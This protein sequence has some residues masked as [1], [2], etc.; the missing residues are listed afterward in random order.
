MHANTNWMSKCL[1]KLAMPSDYVNAQANGAYQMKLET[2]DEMPRADARCPTKKEVFSKRQKFPRWKRNSL[3]AHHVKEVPEAR[4][5]PGT[6]APE[7]LRERHFQLW[8]LEKGSFGAATVKQMLQE[9]KLAS[10]RPSNVADEKDKLRKEMELAESHHDF[11]EV[12]RIKNRLMELEVLSLQS[13]SKNANALMLAKMNKKN[14]AEIFKNAS[15][16]KPVNVSFSRWWTRSQNYY[17]VKGGSVALGDEMVAKKEVD[18]AKAGEATTAEVVAGAGKLVD[19]QAPVAEGTRLFSL[20]NFGLSISLAELQKFGGAQ[21]A[22]LAF[23]ARKKRIEA[24]SRVQVP[25]NDRRR[26]SLTLTVNDSKQSRA[27]L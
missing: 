21:G 25:S 7:K 10:S 19:T 15:E 18:A 3:S 5:D 2:D 16:L 17:N 4:C 20:H 27:L 6:E 13:K 1:S 8:T 26:H 14:K 23:M 11:S 22:H 12:K 9:K 24:T